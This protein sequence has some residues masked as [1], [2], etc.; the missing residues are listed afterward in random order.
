MNI[1]EKINNMDLR[2]VTVD[3]R[4]GLIL[5]YGT[6]QQLAELEKYCHNNNIVCY[7]NTWFS[8]DYKLEIT[9]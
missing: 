8:E 7:L 9:L 2:K 4:T 3:E 6:D 5:A 1:A